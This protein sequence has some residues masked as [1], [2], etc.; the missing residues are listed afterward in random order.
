MIPEIDIAVLSAKKIYEGSLSFDFDAEAGLL[1]LPFAEF[2]SPVHAELS[3]RI[4]EEGAVEVKGTIVYT[5]RGECSRCREYAENV[6]EGEVDGLFE[7]PKG[8]GETYGY[9]R[10]VRLGELLRDALLFSLP[11]RL[12]CTA[13]ESEERGSV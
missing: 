5:L 4:L 2:A 9:V 8:D 11:S 10:T 6:I 13:C 1:D 12:I 3:Y 7:T